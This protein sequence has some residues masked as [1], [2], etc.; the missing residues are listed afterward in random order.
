MKISSLVFPDQ[1][2]PKAAVPDSATDSTP[3][4]KTPATPTTAAESKTGGDSTTVTPKTTAT[5]IVSPTSIAQPI[6]ASGTPLSSTTTSTVAATLV[7][8]VA[9]T[10]VGASPVA[11]AAVVSLV[12]SNV[13]TTTSTTTTTPLPLSNGHGNGLKNEK[14]LPKAMVKPNVLTHVIDDFVIQEASEPFPVTRQRYPERDGADEPPSKLKGTFRLEAD[15]KNELFFSPEKRLATEVTPSSPSPTDLVPCEQCGKS[16]VR[17]KL[18]KKRF[19]SLPC[20][21]AAK[22]TGSTE[23]QALDTSVASSDDMKTVTAAA[24]PGLASSTSAAT[25][26]T[27]TT[28]G[29][30][31]QSDACLVN[32]AGAAAIP[33]SC[34][35]TNGIAGAATTTARASTPLAAGE[36]ELPVIVHWSVAEVCD[37][38]KNLPGCSDYAE[39]FAIQEIDGQAL[40]LLKE[41]H[42]VNAM[43]MKLGPALKIV[44]K[45]DSM[46][47]TTQPAAS[48]G[49]TPQQ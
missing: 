27:S 4:P 47:V 35:G 38:I 26:T 6:S 29:A 20:A 37:F 5:S 19:C 1:Q 13:T 9:S 34:D 18:K 24:T 31:D 43:G 28:N 36:E 15:C 41:N 2:T 10:L 25:P 12:G 49:E 44:A 14:G 42:L 33:A 11:A 21:R 45:V 32:G 39:D 46:R 7:A 22:T 30:K 48:G 17:A 16:E 23:Q 40:L 3:V 8:S